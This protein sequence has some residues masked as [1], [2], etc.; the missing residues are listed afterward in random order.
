MVCVFICAIASPHRPSSIRSPMEAHAGRT[1]WRCRCVARRDLRR[2]G[3]LCAG[4]DYR[5]RPRRAHAGESFSSPTRDTR[6]PL[7]L[8]DFRSALKVISSSMSIGACDLGANLFVSRVRFRGCDS[9]GCARERQQQQQRQQQRE[10]T[11]VGR[12]AGAKLVRERANWKCAALVRCARGLAGATLGLILRTG[13]VC[14]CV[15]VF[16]RSLVPAH[17]YWPP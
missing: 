7:G 1:C 5:R 14:V 3:G 6:R 16:A 8:V 10:Q 12:P 17:I 15:C 9:S 13:R 4:R 11:R 2:P